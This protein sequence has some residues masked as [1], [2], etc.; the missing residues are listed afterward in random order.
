MFLDSDD[1][2]ENTKLEKQISQI[3]NKKVIYC[4]S[5]KYFDLKGKNQIFS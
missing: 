5:A 2:W 3:K 1:Y 4:T